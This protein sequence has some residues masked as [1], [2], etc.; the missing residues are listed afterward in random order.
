MLSKMTGLPNECGNVL[1]YIYCYCKQKHLPLLNLIVIN[2]AEGRP[3]D[4]CPGDPSSDLPAKQSRV[5]I[6]DWFNHSAPSDDMFKEA[7]AKEQEAKKKAKAAAA[8][9]S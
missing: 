4:D 3:G 8:S 1:Y 7:H 5:F 9:Q 6:Y 2:Q